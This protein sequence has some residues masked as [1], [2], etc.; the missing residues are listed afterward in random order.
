MHCIGKPYTYGHQVKTI[1][2]SGIPYPIEIGGDLRE[3]FHQGTIIIFQRTDS[4]NGQVVY[5]INGVKLLKGMVPGV[6][7]RQQQKETGV[8]IVKMNNTN[9]SE[10]VGN[11]CFCHRGPETG[12]GQGIGVKRLVG[13]VKVYMSNITGPELRMV[14]HVMPDSLLRFFAFDLIERGLIFLS[15]VYKG[16]LLYKPSSFMQT[17]IRGGDHTYLI[18][19]IC[20]LSRYIAHYICH[21]TGLAVAY[22]I[23]LCCYE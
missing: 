2:V 21:P 18:S 11:D 22:T 16:D 10:G 6:V 14:D 9:L 8:P 15:P 4:L 3:K 13:V 23:I 12:K 1:T 20:N 5:G 7:S 17:A 19:K